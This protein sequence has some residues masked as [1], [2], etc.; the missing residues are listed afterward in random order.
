METEHGNVTL[1]LVHKTNFDDWQGVQVGKQ[2]GKLPNRDVLSFLIMNVHLQ[3][4]PCGANKANS[5]YCLASFVGV[6]NCKKRPENMHSNVTWT[7]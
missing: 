7:L 4:L 6:C 3:Y 1:P 5:C 2:K